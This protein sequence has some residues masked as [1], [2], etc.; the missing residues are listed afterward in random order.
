MKVIELT[1]HFLYM[2]VQMSVIAGSSILWWFAS[3][4]T[5]GVALPS[6]ASLDWPAFYEAALGMPWIPMFYTGLFSTAMCLSAEVDF[7]TSS[8][9]EHLF[10]ILTVFHLNL[11]LPVRSRL[12]RVNC[13]L[14]EWNFFFACSIVIISTPSLTACRCL[15][16]LLQCE[17]CLQ[18]KLL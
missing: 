11:H 12:L 4:M 14:S 1:F 15:C 10:Y 3:E 13:E 7:L 8:L 2:I 18:L 9:K 6:L 16:S 17:T 5:S